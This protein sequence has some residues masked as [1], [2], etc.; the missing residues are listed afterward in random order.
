MRLP[1]LTFFFLVVLSFIY[2]GCTQKT[3][4]ATKTA[5]S[6]G[7]TY[8][9]VT[10]DPT[11]TRIYT[12]DNGLKVY[13]SHFENAP[14]IHVFTAVKAGGKNDPASNT[15]LAH[16]LEHMMFKGNQYFGTKDYPEEKK[17]LD[18]IEQLFNQYAQLT[19]PDARKALYKTIDEVSN[20]AATFAIPNEYDKMI[21]LL[22][23]KGL[24]AYTTEDRTVYTVDIPANEVERFLTLEGKRFKQIVNRLFHTELE[25]VYEE[26]N[27]S[28]DNDNWKMQEALY[29]G[30]FKEHPYGTQTVIGTI[31]HLKNPSITEI[32]NYFNTYYRPNNVAICMSGELDFDK[33]IALIDKHFGDWTANEALPSWK[34]TAEKPIDAPRSIEVLGPEKESL[35]MGFRF[36]GNQSEEWLYVTIIDVLLA[37]NNAGLIDIDLKQKQ[38]VLSAGAYVDVMNDYSIHTFRGTPKEGQTLEEVRDLLLE[39]IEKIKTGDFDDWLLEAVINDLKKQEMQK[40][41]SNYANYLRA[42]RM[43]MAFTTDTPWAQEIAFF[44]RISKIKKEDLMQFAQTHY[45]NNYAVVYKKTGADPNT[46]KVEKPAINKVPLNRNDRSPFHETLANMEVEKLQPKFLDFSTDLEHFNIGQLPVISKK[47]VDNDLFSLTY[48]FEFGNNLDPKIGLATGFLDYVGTSDFSPEALKQEFYKLGCSLG[49]RVSGD[50]SKTY[51]S[52]NGLS[53]N[54]EAALRLFE[55]VLAKPVGTQ[56]ALDKLA[57]RIIKSREDNKK[58]KGSIL[59]SG[60]YNY[61][62][63]GA[64]NPT[65]YL[66]SNAD[67]KTTQHEELTNWIGRL[68]NYPHRILYYG[69]KSQSELSQLISTY[70]KVPETFAEVGALKTFEEKDLD[71]PTV[72]WTHYDMVQ[73]E[74]VLLS[75][76][77]LLDNSKTAAIQ[78]FN[79]YF[80]G[81]MNSIVFQEIR[82]AQ[83]LAYSVF[84]TYRQAGEK[85]KADYLFSYVGIQS[86]KQREALASMFD[87]I[88]HLPESEQAFSIAKQAI[89]NKIESERITKS[90]VIFSY[91]SA[92]EKGLDR[93][94]R[95]DVYNEVQLMNYESLSNFHK[96]YIQNKAH[97]LLLIGNRDKIDFNNLKQ[98][99]TVKEVALDELFID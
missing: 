23:G 54:M 48:L 65:K 71:D 25:A 68:S 7:Y 90:N 19:D 6:G 88:N 11:Q 34:K 50:G 93:D 27:R 30:L 91:L 61:V 52:L 96:Q 21:A 49:V 40:D 66:V 84:S 56:E 2:T 59:Q 82:E 76:L 80:G 75:K 44:D 63:Y 39:E 12:L 85:D 98:Y 99:G 37:N 57:D 60:L 69:N 43:V 5:Q 77:E 70:H 10:D 24:N 17:L 47:N 86:D 22:G 87:L 3:S 46:K 15:G 72:Y 20:T 28:L 42:N 38:K 32:I 95:E 94:I 13:L 67:L 55:S 64:D 62:K 16:Y 18:S 41:D 51:V 29:S 8:E 35:R 9:Y 97:S 58:N 33:T 36:D 1:A 53:E 92:L 83:G 45:K 14:R 81:G 74:I 4:F 73:S 78:L 79:Q 26:K 89:L 31:D